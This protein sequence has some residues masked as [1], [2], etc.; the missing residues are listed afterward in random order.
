MR[1]D[2][3]PLNGVQVFISHPQNDWFYTCRYTIWETITHYGSQACEHLL[4]DF[5]AGWYS[6]YWLDCD[7]PEF[8]CPERTLCP[9]DTICLYA[10][11][12]DRA[13]TVITV[14]DGSPYFRAPDFEIE[15]GT[16][17]GE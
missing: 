1:V 8:P 3:E 9:G 14:Y 13:D 10:F 12:Q 11:Y 6:T 7:Q 5:G 15:S 4:E 2:G 17:D 16:Q